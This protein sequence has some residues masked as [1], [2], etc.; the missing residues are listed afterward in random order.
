MKKFLRILTLTITVLMVAV[1]V[2]ASNIIKV[3]LNGEYVDFTDANGNKVEPQIINNRTMVPMRKIFEV[4]GA[5]VEWLPETRSIKSSSDG[6]EI[7]LQ[8]DNQIATVTDKN[9]VTKEIQLD[10]APTIVNDRT[11]VPVR[12]IAESLDKKVDW[13]GKNRIVII[14]DKKDEEMNEAL[15]QA[16]FAAFRT[17]MGDLEDAVKIAIAKANGDESIRGNNRTEAQLYNFVARG[18]YEV[19]TAT[20]AGDGKWLTNKN[21]KDIPC[22]K[23]E[24][25]YAKYSLGS[26][27]P[28][29]YVKT[30]KNEKEQLEYFVTPKGTI[31]C[32]P[33]YEYD[34]KSY[35]ASNLTVKDENGNELSDLQATKIKKAYIKTDDKE[36]I[37]I[38][39]GSQ[40]EFEKESSKNIEEDK[41]MFE[42]RD[43]KIENHTE[44]LNISCVYPKIISFN[45]KEFE[46]YINN[47]I[48]SNINAY[49]MEI[50]YLVGDD[51][52]LDKVYKYVVTY[53]KY[54]YSKYASVI[55]NQ[56]Y[57]TGGI[58]SNKWK[59]TYNIDLELEKIIYL[60]D[61]FEK[62]NYEETIVNEINKQANQK[63]IILMAGNGLKKISA[64][65]KFYIK[66]K[67]LI[68]CFDPS[69]VANPKYGE[70][71]FEMPF[72]M[73][74]KGYF[75]I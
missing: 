62:D 10:S 23:I 72:A 44:N 53:D 50:M 28:T 73:N 51:T 26:N 22:T 47:E 64:K 5:D 34:G 2:F 40:V 55:I 20:D 11:L 32:W 74:S 39:N 54:V 43:I 37:I 49:R 8:I 7:G 69:E 17:E 60:D 71:E 4:L 6:L 41:V 48:V 68:I 29:R 36:V 1:P 19:L 38:K 57:E 70:L 56:N 13:D 25:T 27:L 35:V 45:D 3:Q 46:K 9:G 31:F 18:G 66:D 15:S 12:F 61:L 16:N 33:P 52:P 30:Y 59:D 58:R 24:A 75:E 65:Q 14:K 42:I 21:A 67:K 63:N